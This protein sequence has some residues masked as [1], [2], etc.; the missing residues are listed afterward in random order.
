MLEDRLY[1]ADP[2]DVSPPNRQSDFLCT[3]SGWLVVVALV[4]APLA[5][6]S[7]PPAA[8]LVME[9]TLGLAILF[10]AGSIIG[11]RQL[12]SV[13]PVVLVSGLALLAMGWFMAWNASGAW[14]PAQG[15]IVSRW[16]PVPSLP[17]SEEQAVSIITMTRI[18]ILFATLLLVSDL[19][20]LLVWRERF[21]LAICCSGTAV[22]LIGLA[23]L[24]GMPPLLRSM[25][26]PREGAYFSTFNYHGNAGAYLNLAL[27]PLC[28][29]AILRFARRSKAAT[30]AAALGML[31]AVLAAAFANTSRGAQAISAVI[32]L[33]MAI[34]GVVYLR[35]RRSSY[36]KPRFAA[37]VSVIA[38]LGLG[39][40]AA[41]VSLH[42]AKWRQLPLHLSEQS[43]R[44][45][46][47]KVAIPMARAAG[48]LGHGPGT[49]KM[50][51]PRSPLVT[52]ALTS[53]WI[54]QDHIPGGQVSMWSMAHQDYLQ[55]YFEYGLLGSLAFATILFGGIGLAVVRA[56]NATLEHSEPWEAMWA[57]MGCALLGI[58]AN[59]LFDFP[60]QV[61]SLQLTTAVLL[62]ICWATG[63]PD[64]E[65]PSRSA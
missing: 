33:A 53:V 2:D 23:Q 20:A 22:A 65:I 26:N 3:A 37:G 12:P 24:L 15:M 30:K 56:V 9:T 28:S 31:L 7:T 4:F 48:P 19:A 59:A 51:L 13:R 43:S 61:A 38:L 57:G 6:G 55:T 11:A 18:T 32:V 10:W 54:I 40:V 5:L 64:R 63:L 49:F 17:G 1:R 21:L 45:N 62:G 52:N 44:Q 60:L 8:I 29:L 25:L 36:A 16:P 58:A 34:W 27:A 50:L 46:V 47:W 41:S 42:S 39:I 14:S 35:T